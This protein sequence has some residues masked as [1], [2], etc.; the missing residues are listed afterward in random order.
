LLIYYD[1]SIFTLD[2][3]IALSER[4]QL[5]ALIVGILTLCFA[6]YDIYRHMNPK[7]EPGDQDGEELELLPFTVQINWPERGA[8]NRRSS[9]P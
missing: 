2:P 7:K 4:D 6:I 1:S 8:R 5:S 9:V 3:G